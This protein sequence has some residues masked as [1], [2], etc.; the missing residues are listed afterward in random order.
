[1]KRLLIVYINRWF[2]LIEHV[3]FFPLGSMVCLGL[4]LTIFLLT[5]WYQSHFLS[6]YVTNLFSL[7]SLVTWTYEL[8]FWQDG[9]C[10]AFESQSEWS[11]RKKVVDHDSSFKFIAHD[12]INLYTT[13]V[14]LCVQFNLI[15]D[16]PNYNVIPIAKRL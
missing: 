4:P 2:F 13:A 9:F 15:L 6:K 8:L 1:M 14:R 16:D 5:F 7:F 11:G 3:F 12:I 10:Y